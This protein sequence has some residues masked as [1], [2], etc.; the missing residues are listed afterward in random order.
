MVEKKT[1]TTERAVGRRKQASAR[2]RI[3]LGKGNILINDRELT[4]F[5]PILILQKKVTS[6]LEVVGKD[7][8]FDVSVKVTGGGVHGQADAVRHGIARALVKWN[9]DFKPLLKVEGYLTRDSRVK[10]RKKPGFR[11]ARRGRQWKKR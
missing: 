1:E 9:E 2:V 8:D 3:T 11:K 4:D 7:K 10:E 6:P 5:F